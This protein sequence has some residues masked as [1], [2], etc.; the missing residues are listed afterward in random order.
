PSANGAVARTAVDARGPPA[1]D[2]SNG[3]G[4]AAAGP[5]ETAR[6]TRAAPTAAAQ[7]R[8]SCTV[9]DPPNRAD[10]LVRL[11]NAPA[12]GAG[13]APT[14]KRSLE[15]RFFCSVVL[16]LRHPDRR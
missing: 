3:A 14:A 16:G 13:V 7:R 11:G 1:D 5:A 2:A 6:T 12:A 9:I 15:A 10:G 8:E 4:P